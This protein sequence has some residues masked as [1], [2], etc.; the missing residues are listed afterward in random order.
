MFLPGVVVS[1]LSL[2]LHF[3]RTLTYK[4]IRF[5]SVINV[6]APFSYASSLM[7]VCADLSVAQGLPK[8]GCT[9]LTLGKKK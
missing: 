8:T 4:I 2:F 5:A 1:L 9:E 3:L 6:L 7:T